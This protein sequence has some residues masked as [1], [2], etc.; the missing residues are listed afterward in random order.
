MRLGTGSIGAEPHRCFDPSE[1]DAF[2]VRFAAGS[3]ICA[4]D[5]R[6]GGPQR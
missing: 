5:A 1:L 2:L 3:P 6:I 4:T